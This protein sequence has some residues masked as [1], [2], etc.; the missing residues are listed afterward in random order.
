VKQQVTL[1]AS[2]L[3]G[4]LLAGMLAVRGIS[5]VVFL[6]LGGV[7]VALAAHCLVRGGFP[8]ATNQNA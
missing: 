6:P 8:G 4:A 1:I 3:L 2:Y 5:G 7:A